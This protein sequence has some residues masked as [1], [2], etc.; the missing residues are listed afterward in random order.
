[1]KKEEQNG[2]KGIVASVVVPVY[3]A[4]ARLRACLDCYA[5][6]TLEAIEIICVDD[7]STDRSHGILEEYARKD[8]RF[9]IIEQE[10]S[11][12][13]IAR[14]R[15]AAEAGGEWVFFGDADD[16]CAPEMLSEWRRPSA[17]FRALALKT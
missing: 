13:A 4:Q 9:R 3:N 16:E 10:N 14:N 7:G 8:S 15:G 17:I 6:Q 1:M 5:A 12:A 2:Q 11:G